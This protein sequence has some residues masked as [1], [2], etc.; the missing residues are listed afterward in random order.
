MSS[1]VSGF[2][3]CFRGEYEAE[4]LNRQVIEE[5]HDRGTL[6]VRPMFNVI[7]NASGH[8]YYGPLISF[9]AY[10]DELQC[11]DEDGRL[12]YENLL[13][14]FVRD[15]SEVIHGYSGERCVWTCRRSPVETECRASV[16]AARRVF[17]SHHGLPA[18]QE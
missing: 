11:F 2:I 1:I 4:L 15:S 16:V 13:K 14:R 5:L 12:Q 9:A 8:C 6:I 17:S 7:P 3:Q 10:Y 18:I